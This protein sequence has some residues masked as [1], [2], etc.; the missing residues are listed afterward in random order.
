MRGDGLTVT[1]TS[2]GPLSGQSVIVAVS[3]STTFV[4]VSSLATVA[5]GDAVEI[6][7]PDAGGSPVLADKV[8]DERAPTS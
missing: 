8:Y 6:H 5:A 1:V 2:G 4:G 7:A 3:Q